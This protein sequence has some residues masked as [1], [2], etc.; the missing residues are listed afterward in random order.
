MVTKGVYGVLSIAKEHGHVERGTA[1]SSLS[2]GRALD[3]KL[4]KPKKVKKYT[5]KQIK[6]L[7]SIG[8]TKKE[9]STTKTVYTITQKGKSVLN[10]RKKR[11]K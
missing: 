5:D 6:Q 10:K 4:I 9:L 7:M 1:P 8:Y 11:K 2:L 3:Q